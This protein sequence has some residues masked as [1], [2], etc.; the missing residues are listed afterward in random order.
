MRKFAP[1]ILL[2]ASLALTGAPALAHVV[3]SPNAA[4]PGDSVVAEFKAGHGCTKEAG[5]TGVRVAIP[6]GVETAHPLKLEGWTESVEKTGER[7]TAVSW[8]STTASSAPVTF[9]LHIVLPQA[10]GPLAFNAV[11]TCGAVQ[12]VWDGSN[13][14]HP[15]PTIAV[16]GTPSAAPAANHEGHEH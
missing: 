3:V 12:S 13:K 7:I 2:G 9:Q 11:Q 8:T 15:A 14:E 6:E 16:G 5:T 1:L 4:G 10:K